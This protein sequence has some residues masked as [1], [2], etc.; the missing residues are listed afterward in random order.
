MDPIRDFDRECKWLL[1][2]CLERISTY[3]PA[4]RQPGRARLE[5]Q[6]SLEHKMP[7]AFH[8]A[9]L[10]PFWLEEPL[11][12]DRN[13]CRLVGLSSTFLVLYFM[14]QDELMDAEPEEYEGHLQPLATFLLLDALAPYHRVFGSE[15][16]FWAL[17]EEYIA[18]W[19]LSISWE[20][21]WHWGQ[22]RAFEEADLILLARK[23]APLKISCAALCLLAGRKEATELLEKMIDDLM[24]S[25]L[26]ADDLQDWRGDLAQGSY[27]Y[28]LTRV[29]AHRRL[30]PH[31]TLTETDV[32]K[33][34]FA[35]AVLDEYL[36][37]IAEYR[38]RALESASA[39]AVPYLEAYLALRDEAA[40]QLSVDLEARRTEWIREQ[41]AALIPKPPVPVGQPGTGSKM[42]GG[43]MSLEPGSILPLDS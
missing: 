22:V 38:R 26:L 43:H 25:F 23:A 42:R 17:F 36:G 8:I 27:T 18:Q 4:L 24:M 41:F 20:R 21:Q 34:L 37:L 6:W 13:V 31:T 32:E 35:G 2:A 3:P 16:A 30:D 40:R 33:A 14:L 29:L 15:P 9:Y 28:F 5:D 19:G 12:L 39:L 11:A 7:R 1:D 10:L